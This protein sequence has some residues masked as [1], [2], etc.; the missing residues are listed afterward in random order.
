[1][2]HRFRF[3]WTIVLLLTITYASSALASDKDFCVYATDGIAYTDPESGLVQPEAVR[4]WYSERKQTY[5][6]FQ[7]S[8]AQT[9]L[10]WLE[11][12]D[13]AVLDGVA[14]QSGVNAS[15]LLDGEA[16]TLTVGKKKYS[17]RAMRSA[18]V[19][20]MFMTTESSSLSYIH[21]KKGNQETGTLH[22]LDAAGET[23]YDGALAHIK[24]RGNSTFGLNK[25]P[26]QIKL[27]KGAD[28]S[29]MG[30]AKTWILLAEY[31][32]NSLLRNRLAFAMANAVGMPYASQSQTVD[33]YINNDYLGA[34]T[35]C[36]KVEIGD[37][38]VNITDLQK[39][40]EAVNDAAL[41]TYPRYGYNSYR[42]NTQKGYKIPN[43]PEDITGGYLL[44]MDYKMRYSDEVSGFV[45]AK[46]QA[47]VVK[48]PE[49]ASV[50]QA[51]YIAGIMQ[52]FENAIR[53]KDGIDPK[54]GRHYTTFVD[55]QSLVKKYILEEMLKNRDANR[56]SL[57]FYKPTDSESTVAFAGPAWDYD[58]A[59]GNYATRADDKN[60][61]P[62]G[63]VANSDWGES[64]YIFP[65]L[66]AHTDFR[67][68]VTDAYHNAF[69]PALRV[70]LGQEK[71][72][73]GV[74]KSLQAYADE[75]VSS[76]AMNFVRW[77][78]FNIKA[79]IAQTGA[80]YQENIDYVLQFLEARM[81]FLDGVWPVQ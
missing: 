48:E 63:F 41:D 59:M 35:L 67:E 6:L 30:M 33:V 4:W 64:F 14:I 32:D 76:A 22:M 10:L 72:S 73:N 12:A 79:R 49:N 61:L 65:R 28:L 43:D 57:Y 52:G 20:A 16:H 78:V 25:K 9:L 34:Y 42:I 66:Y 44:E 19:P 2:R 71:D 11:G 37:T 13:T 31:R 47:V 3:L 74:L 39:E 55:M 38:R 27:D 81:A 62:T 46:G 5:Y 21:Y 18:N 8:Y 1:M 58:A 68:A 80:N 75:I 51:T 26:Y 70:L 60:L 23:L 69:V 54:S 77:P 40:T 17:L 36:E 29:G 56:S 24:G 15:T 50:Q 7:P 45:T 53:A